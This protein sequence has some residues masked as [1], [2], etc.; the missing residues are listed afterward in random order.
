MP[1]LP[2][3]EKMPTRVSFAFNIG[4]SRNLEP[5]TASGSETPLLPT[6]P[7]SG[8]LATDPYYYGITYGHTLPVQPFLTGD[9]KAWMVPV[10]RRIQ[11]D[12]D[13]DIWSA[14]F[15][16]IGATVG[17]KKTVSHMI[18]RIAEPQQVALWADNHTCSWQPGEDLSAGGHPVEQHIFEGGVEDDLFIPICGTDYEWVMTEVQTTAG[19]TIGAGLAEGFYEMKGW[20][21]C[22]IDITWSRM[23]LSAFEEYRP[24]DAAVRSFVKYVKS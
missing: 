16:S 6:W 24:R 21:Q 23:S 3:V 22:R 12:Y 19:T 10:I 2:K 8:V 4:S 11:Y 1:R 18:K 5:P 20:V 14:E 13:L 7:P 9:N 15:F 17:G